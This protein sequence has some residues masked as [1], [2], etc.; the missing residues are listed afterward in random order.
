[1]ED[2]YRETLKEKLML[3][4]EAHAQHLADSLEKQVHTLVHC[5][6]MP[7]ESNSLNLNPANLNSRVITSTGCDKVATTWNSD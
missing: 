1:M 5:V 4:A 7:A 6:Y 2:S 3:Q